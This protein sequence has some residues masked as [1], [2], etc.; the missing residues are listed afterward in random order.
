MPETMGS[1][2]QS[3]PSLQLATSDTFNSLCFQERQHMCPASSSSG[4][5]IRPKVAA[6]S[7]TSAFRVFF[8]HRQSAVSHMAWGPLRKTDLAA[9]VIHY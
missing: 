9:P 8:I 2:A 4:P 5:Q 7:E 1:D 6:K 3:S